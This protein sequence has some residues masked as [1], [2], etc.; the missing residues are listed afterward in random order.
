MTPLYRQESQVPEPW[1]AQDSLGVSAKVQALGLQHPSQELSQRI[2]TSSVL[3]P[4]APSWLIQES[5]I[6]LPHI[7]QS[8][9]SRDPNEWPP[10][11]KSCRLGKGR[12]EESER[13]RPREDRRLA[14]GRRA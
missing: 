2:R 11:R 1:L 7:T 12:R 6:H 10:T 3:P 14:W 5:S 4:E 9:G 13:R 8:A